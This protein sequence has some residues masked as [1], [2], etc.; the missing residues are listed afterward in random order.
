MTNYDTVPTPEK[1]GVCDSNAETD[2]IQHQPQFF[3]WHKAVTNLNGRNLPSI[4][5]STPEMLGRLFGC[6]GRATK[7]RYLFV[8]L[9]ALC[10]GSVCITGLIVLATLYRLLLNC[11][12]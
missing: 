11:L 7:R 6:V 10:T 9:A 8:L 12:R 3:D 1:L 4:N 2:L 5:S